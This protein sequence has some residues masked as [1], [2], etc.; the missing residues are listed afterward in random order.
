MSNRL[1]F[2]EANGSTRVDSSPEHAKRWTD[3]MAMWAERT[4]FGKADSWY[5]GANVPG[6]TRQLLNL[7]SSDA[8]LGA[9]RQCAANGYD[10]FLFD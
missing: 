6:K 8:Y 3:T 9:L 4:L 10:G 7:P 2:A 5:M 1:E